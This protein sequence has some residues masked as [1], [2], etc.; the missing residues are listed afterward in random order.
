MS[1][2]SKNNT[3]SA[4]FTNYE[5]SLLKYGTQSERIGSDSLKKFDYCS[6]CL[7]LAIDPLTCPRG[8][9]YC[10]GC[11]YEYLLTQKK[12]ISKQLEAWEAQ[13]ERQKD[14]SSMKEL[15]RQQK[16][17]DD[18]DKNAHGLLPNRPEVFQ[19][20]GDKKTEDEEPKK[21]K[22][23]AFW[24]PSVGAAPPPPT[25]LKKP[26]LETKC[27][28]GHTLRLKQLV[29]LNFTANKNVDA[30]SQEK[31][32]YQCPACCKTITN[33]VKSVALKKCGHVTCDS[34]FQTFKKDKACYVCG[35]KFKEKEVVSLVCGTA[36][37]GSSGEK[38]KPKVFS[39]TAWL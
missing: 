9:I 20:G 30:A 2:H 15:E 5:R 21:L 17:Y 31:G 14:D 23:N 13:E 6:L 22:M 25:L 12:E 8:N 7:H 16:E 39:P 38:L 34:C 36:Y 24:L 1:R 10:K 32:R 37:S 3:A 19:K 11:I 26:S 33:S 28:Y 27:P 4:V 29:K 35:Q 18:F